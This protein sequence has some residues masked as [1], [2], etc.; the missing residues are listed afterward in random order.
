MDEK[1]R[2]HACPSL[3]KLTRAIAADH[4]AAMMLAWTPAQ[5]RMVVPEEVPGSE[6]AIRTAR[7]TWNRRDLSSSRNRMAWIGAGVALLT[8]YQAWLGWNHFQQ[9]AGKSGVEI[10]FPTHLRLTLQSLVHS[11]AVG[12]GIMAWILFAFLPWYQARKSRRELDRWNDRGLAAAVP[13]LRFD[14]WLQQQRAPVTRYFLCLI[15]GVGLSQIMPGSSLAAAGLVKAS[16]LQGESWRL[17][18]APFLHGNIVHFLMNAAALAYL[19]KRLE[20]FA[21]WPHLVLVFLFSAYIG[22][23]ASVQ[24][25]DP[26]GTAI[27]ASGGLMGWLGFLLVFETLH[28]KLVPKTVRKRLLAGVFLT[29]FIGLIGYRYIDNAAHF[30]GLL[31]GMLYAAIVFPKSSSVYRPRSTLTDLVAGGAA[32][33]A[34]T[35]MAAFAIWRI[36]AA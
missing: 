30:G 34:L 23:L 8:L 28:A 17:F 5:S 29:A 15:A 14:T 13:A 1:G 2:Q 26:R 10:S 35:G 25:M 7:E 31:A 20:T 21:R 24:F 22:G 36:L 6:S 27:G 16:Y 11:T 18:T 3:E 4:D 33:V 9:L 12:I 19:G 32:L